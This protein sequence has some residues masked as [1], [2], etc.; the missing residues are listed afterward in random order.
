MILRGILKDKPLSNYLWSHFLSL[1]P[2]QNV[3]RTSFFSAR[4]NRVFFAENFEEKSNL[5]HF[6]PTGFHELYITCEV[7]RAS[8]PRKLKWIPKNDAF[9]EGISLSMGSFSGGTFVFRGVNSL[10]LA[11]SLTRNTGA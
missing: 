2:P 7:L 9:Q 4:K 3:E 11:I 8:T 6:Y 10:M 1:H 5:I